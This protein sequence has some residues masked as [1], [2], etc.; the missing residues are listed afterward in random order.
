MKDYK[1]NAFGHVLSLE[2]NT[3][4]KAT[5]FFY[6]DMGRPLFVFSTFQ[7]SDY[8]ISKMLK[9]ILEDLFLITRKG[10]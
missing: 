6:L 5:S 2:G 9:Q 4:N 10:H 1:W 7:T 8:R 3:R